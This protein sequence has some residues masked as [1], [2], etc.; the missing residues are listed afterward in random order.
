M[1]RLGVLAMVL[2]VVCALLALSAAGASAAAP[3]WW[4]CQKAL[5]K[6]T[7]HY[8]DKLCGD[9][10]ESGGKYELVPG[11][12]K[13]KS[14]K[15]KSSG[16]TVLIVIIPGKAELKI[17]CM[18]TIESGRVA[19]PN[20]EVGV[21][22]SLSK[23]QLLGEPCSS[24]STAP[25]AGELGWINKEKDQVGVSLTNEAAPGSGYVAQIECPGFAKFRV[26]GSFIGTQTGDVGHLSKVASTAWSTEAI[27]LGPGHYDEVVNDPQSFEEGPNEVL[28]TE[29][30]D[31]EDHEKF[32]P[33]GGYYSALETTVPTKGETLLIQ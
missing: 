12:G 14:F 5:P 27:D 4:A 15:G 8:S 31:I 22:F 3:G 32:G 18:K 11:V 29:I 30:F 28:M 24:F 10:V 33:E 7:G 19:A 2:S 21:T 26:V 1:R 9:A 6:N 16:R 23:C 20:L 25:L 13:G 17:E